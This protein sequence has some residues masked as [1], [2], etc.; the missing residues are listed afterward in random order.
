MRG[1]ASEGG[2]EGRAPARG[3]AGEG[4]RVPARGSTSKGECQRGWAPARVRERQGGTPARV[5]RS[6]KGTTD[7]WRSGW[8]PE[9]RTVNAQLWEGRATAR[10]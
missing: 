5:A 7:R 6:G 9:R 4:G 3:S 1:S 2:R 8:P 10:S